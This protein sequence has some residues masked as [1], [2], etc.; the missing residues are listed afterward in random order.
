MQGAILDIKQNADNTMS[1][2]YRAT[3]SKATAIREQELPT[4]PCMIYT[5]DGRPVGSDISSLPHG[6]YVV[7]G[8]KVVR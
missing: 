7:D 3:A 8:K 2:R 1:F 5:L 4:V 6:I